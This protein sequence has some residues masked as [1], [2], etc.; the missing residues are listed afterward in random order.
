MSKVENFYP[1]A[2]DLKTGD[3]IIV[4]E[5]L[6]ALLTNGISLGDTAF[7]HTVAHS[8][9]IVVIS[10]EVNSNFLATTVLADTV[11]ELK[12]PF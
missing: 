3:S 11:V 6:N 12:P 9:D 8:E 5:S 1:T 7:I 10:M 4:T 2:R